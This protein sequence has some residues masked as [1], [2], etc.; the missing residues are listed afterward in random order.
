MSESGGMSVNRLTAGGQTMA[1]DVKANNTTLAAN[2]CPA[3]A[4]P[5]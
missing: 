5:R 1:T 3:G 4:T 2:L